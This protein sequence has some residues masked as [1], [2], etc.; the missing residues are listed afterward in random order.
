MTSG[1]HSQFKTLA[2]FGKHPKAMAAALWVEV[3][4]FLKT[5][6]CKVMVHETSANAVQGHGFDSYTLEQ[7]KTQADAAVVVGGDGTLLGVAR[8]LADSQ[9]PMIGV[10][11]GRLGFMTDIPLDDLQTHLGDIISGNFTSE[12]RSYFIAEVIRAGKIIHS[13]KALNDVVITRGMIGGMIDIGVSVDNEFMYDLRADALIASTPTG[14]TAY[15]LSAHGPIL[16]PS[17]AGIVIVPVAPHA[18]TNRPIALPETAKVEIRI[19]GGKETSVHFDMQNNAQT[20]VGDIIRV[21]V[22]Q[23]PIRLIHPLQYDYFSMLRQKL[24]WSTSP[25]D[26]SITSRGSRDIGH[27]T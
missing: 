19:Q 16:H 21:Y 2:V 8:E 12:S 9:V 26:W 18:L 11:Q 14:S 25:T 20:E 15:S 23:S 27:A 7:I 24:H 6:G 5:Q 3:A 22:A 1:I 13:A 10:N 17:L 4:N